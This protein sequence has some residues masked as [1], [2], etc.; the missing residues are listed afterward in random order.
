MLKPI[1]IL[2]CLSIAGFMC[3][4]ALAIEPI[5]PGG[6]NPESNVLFCDG[7]ETRNLSNW[8]FIWQESKITVN[9]NPTYVHSGTYSLQIHYQIAAGGNAHKDDN[10][11]VSK[12]RDF[13]SFLNPGL[14]NFFV[15]GY[16][17]HGTPLSGSENIQRKLYYFMDPQGPG[18]VP[19][20]YWSVVLTSFNYQLALNAGCPSGSVSWNLFTLKPNTWYCVEVEVKA[21]TLGQSDGYVNVWVDGVQVLNRANQ[22]LRCSYDTGIVTIQVGDQ[23][24]RLNSEQVDEY[25]Y[26]DDIVIS[27]S[28]IGPI[29]SPPPK[30]PSNLR[31]ISD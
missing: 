4:T 24:D 13:S 8:D 18:G 14:T 7:F 27:K 29:G 30:P 26:W 17:Y 10:E 11:F 9:S 6:S 22:N 2:L 5:C 31:V 1:S 28:Y 3:G 19:P 16:V 25:R 15:R 20:Y 12:K 21:N 23:V